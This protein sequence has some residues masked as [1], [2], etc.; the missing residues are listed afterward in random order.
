MKLQT[1]IFIVV[2]M[3]LALSVLLLAQYATTPNLGLKK[4]NP[5]VNGWDVYIN[6]NFDTLDTVTC[7]PTVFN[8]QADA[9]TVTW[10]IANAP[11]ANASLTFT[12]HSGSRTL[13]ITN[14]VSGGSYVIWLKQ[15]GTGGEGLTL[16][17]GCVWKVIGGGAGAVSLSSS[18]SAI[19]ILTFTYDG[20]NCY[21]NLGKN[22][23]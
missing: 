16:G 21:A 4:P 20:T 13:N 10:A 8:A 1:K 18:A 7:A 23:S 22:Y 11:C 12:V 2:F 6:S 15:D 19:D 17:T 14:P 5:G 3:S 9:A